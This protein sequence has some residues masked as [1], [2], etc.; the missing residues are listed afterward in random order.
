MS[1]LKNAVAAFRRAISGGGDPPPRPRTT[2]PPHIRAQIEA[3][4]RLLA[5]MESAVDGMESAVGEM[6]E[7]R[8]RITREIGSRNE[9]WVRRTGR[10]F[11]ERPGFDKDMARLRRL[12]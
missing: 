12:K 5:S 10:P 7:I 3:A 2:L 11:E 4:D 8:A 9:E 6:T 1:V